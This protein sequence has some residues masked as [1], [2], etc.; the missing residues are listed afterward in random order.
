MT[1]KQQ[2]PILLRRDFEVT[3][4]I[5]KKKR[6]K[7]EGVRRSFQLLHKPASLLLPHK[8]AVITCQNAV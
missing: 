7:R 3:I 6:E 8:K 4:L 5:F 2:N 1:V